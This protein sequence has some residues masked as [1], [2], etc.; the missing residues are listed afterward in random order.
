M[1]FLILFQ[2]SDKRETE[3]ARGFFARARQE[4][5]SFILFQYET[6]NRTLEKGGELVLF[7]LYKIFIHIFHACIVQ[8]NIVYT[9]IPWL[10]RWI[11]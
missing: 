10:N 4:R 8:L 5:H 9:V 11:R 6:K 2:A 1:V 7:N 3:R